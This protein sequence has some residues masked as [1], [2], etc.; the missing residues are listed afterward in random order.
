MPREK[1]FKCKLPGMNSDGS[2][3]H[4]EHYLGRW[5][6]AQRKVMKTQNKGN[7]SD[8]QVSKLQSLIDE[9]N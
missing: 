3:Y 6:F 9:G 4:Y 7:L 5:V 2:T 1:I 8:E